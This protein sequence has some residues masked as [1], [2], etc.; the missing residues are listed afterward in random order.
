MKRDRGR[1][2]IGIV[3]LLLAAGAITADRMAAP[4]AVTPRPVVP[5]APGGLLA[6]PVLYQG[7]GDAW[8]NVA[9]V[10][11]EASKVIVTT[12]R[13][14]ADPLFRSFTLDAG[15]VTT[16]GLDS[17][18]RQKA[19]AIVQ[20]SGGEVV[21]SRATTFRDSPGR[22]GGVA[23]A[24]RRAGDR[25]IVIPS[26]STLNAETRIV[27]LNPS[28]SDAAA[29]ISLLVDGEERTP[30]GLKGFEVQPRSRREFRV[31]D[32]AFD[33]RNVAT[34]IR[35]RTGVMVADGILA[36]ERGISITPG[37]P[38]VRSAAGVAVT[39]AGAGLLDLVTVGDQD[40]VSDASLFSAEGLTAFAALS[41][42]VEPLRPQSTSLGEEREAATGVVLS[43]RDGSPV[44][45]ALRWVV[46]LPDG[47]GDVSGSEM[48][49]PAR[50]LV[51][52]S[53]P[54]AV[55]AQSRVLIGNPGDVDATVTLRILTD[56]GVS[57]AQPQ[58]S[59]QAG[60][61]VSVPIGDVKGPFA[62]IVT[63]T[64]PVAMTITSTV[65]GSGLSSFTVTGQP[66]PSSVAVPVERDPRAGVPAR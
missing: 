9:N 18:V 2:A 24:C 3:A 34:V 1:L 66:M 46:Q 65:I 28:T 52:V 62:V 61:A 32:F 39:G 33:A 49:A 47:R 17:A 14:G 50:R 30:E 25:T 64:A 40:T 22:S 63:S 41:E 56:R 16:M 53:G 35:V 48:R 6:C 45:A 51:A 13:E 57:D 43:V 7:N 4:A 11:D 54:P 60:R 15:K 5:L 37:G 59:V 42:A 38:P 29:E 8:L 44:A 31:G 21:A 19:G 12:V 10:G 36:S 23:A 58:V 27:L 20:F 26:G 55:A